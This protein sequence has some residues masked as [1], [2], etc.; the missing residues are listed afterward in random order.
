MKDIG[1]PTVA[2]HWESV[3]Q[4]GPT[5]AAQRKE[6]AAVKVLATQLRLHPITESFL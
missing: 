1:T 2:T 3:Q 5:Q 4:P 6:Q